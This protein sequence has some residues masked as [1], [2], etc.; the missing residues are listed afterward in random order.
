VGLAKERHT[1]ALVVGLVLG[2]LAGAAVTLWKTPR[3]GAQLRA[4][5][6]ERTEEVLFRLTG[7]DKAQ[8]WETTPPSPPP[9]SYRP[10]SR[11]DEAARAAAVTAPLPVLAP[12]PA[13]VAAAPVDD[14][15]LP[16]TFRG[17]V[18]TDQPTDVVL[19]GPRPA[20]ADR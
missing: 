20:P 12:E 13:D 2:G 19:D 9:S 16:P 18:L 17:E 7:M 4:L 1:T 15:I 14:D 10:A 5:V 3:S 11:R 8:T 6:A